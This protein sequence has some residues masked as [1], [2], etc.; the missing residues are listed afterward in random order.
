MQHNLK[1]IG[2]KTD[3]RCYV[4]A[5]IGINHGGSMRQAVDLVESAAKTG[6]HAVKFQTYNAEQRV[7]DKRILCDI[8]KRCE[9]DLSSFRELKELSEHLGLDFFS[10]AFDKESLAYLIKIGVEIFKI[11]S[12]DVTNGDL[13]KATAET[14]K[15]LLMSVGMASA[16]EICDSYQ[17]IKSFTIKLLSCIVCFLSSQRE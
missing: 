1:S 6:C 14:K 9:L 5:E 16:K 4:I 13:L 7:P 10:T 17:L 8:L 2:L 11:A 15:T 3:D 12:F